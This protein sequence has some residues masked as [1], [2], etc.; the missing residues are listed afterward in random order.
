MS[1]EEKVLE[2]IEVE[3]EPVRTETE[4]PVEAEVT[5][6]PMED[7]EEKPEAPA[8]AASVT[9]QVFTDGRI[10]L[11]L[12]EGFEDLTERDVEQMT[13]Q[14]YENLFEKRMADM[15]LD[16]LKARLQ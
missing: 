10:E 9:I 16:M 14:V 2:A 12:P 3:A 8:L 13:K 4:A 15:A 11:E 7:M 5:E 1:N 6:A